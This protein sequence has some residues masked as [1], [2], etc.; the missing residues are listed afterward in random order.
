[1]K[2]KLFAAVVVSAVVSASAAVVASG[3]PTVMTGTVIDQWKIKRGA[4]AGVDVSIFANPGWTN[5][6]GMAVVVN[7][8]S[9]TLPHFAVVSLHT[10]DVPHVTDGSGLRV[11]YRLV[12]DGQ[13]L[14]TDFLPT[15]RPVLGSFDS[16]A[17]LATGNRLVQMQVAIP[18]FYCHTPTCGLDPGEPEP[19]IHVSFD[20]PWQLG[21]QRVLT[22]Y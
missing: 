14:R 5:V 2:W 8:P 3:A 13:P 7:F 22:T 6:P 21:V 17:I 12:L 20:A 19:T 16:T 1:M 15:D 4:N 9:Q 10:E 18:E 11:D